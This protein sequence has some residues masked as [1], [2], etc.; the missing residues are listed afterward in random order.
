[1]GLSIPL[2]MYENADIKMTYDG[3]ECKYVDEEC[4]SQSKHMYT[5]SIMVIHMQSLDNSEKLHLPKRLWWMD[6]KYLQKCVHM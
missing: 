3:C 1:M 5:I 6:A 2:H 4:V